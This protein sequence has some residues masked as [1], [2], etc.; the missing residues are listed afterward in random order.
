MLEREDYVLKI[1]SVVVVLVVA[2]LNAWLF[3]FH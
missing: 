1:V 2:L 3:I